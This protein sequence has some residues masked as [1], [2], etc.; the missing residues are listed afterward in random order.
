[1]RLGCPFTVV[2]WSTRSAQTSGL[3]AFDLSFLLAWAH[4]EHAKLQD[5]QHRVSIPYMIEVLRVTLHN[6]KGGLAGKIIAKSCAHWRYFHSP[7]R[8]DNDDSLTRVECHVGKYVGR[9]AC[10]KQTVAVTNT[11]PCPSP[12][13]DEETTGQVRA[14]SADEERRWTRN[15]KPLS[16]C[17]RASLSEDTPPFAPHLDFPMNATYERTE[18]HK[19][20]T[21][22]RMLFAAKQQRSTISNNERSETLLS[23][24]TLLQL[25]GQSQPINIHQHAVPIHTIVLNRATCIYTYIPGASRETA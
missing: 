19:S 24:T 7:W 6:S 2:L 15:R 20:T 1:M 21:N 16:S 11:C 3:R 12:Q 14:T 4:G 17:N 10:E 13:Q 25:N 23:P 18:R 9:C 5:V 22:R 8:V